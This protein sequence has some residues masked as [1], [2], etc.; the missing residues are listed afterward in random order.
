MSLLV[1]GGGDL[2]QTGGWSLRAPCICS[3]ALYR[4]GCPLPIARIFL[5]ALAVLIGSV[6]RGNDRVG[7]RGRY[8]GGIGAVLQNQQARWSHGTHRFLGRDLVLLWKQRQ[9][10]RR[11]KRGIATSAVSEGAVACDGFDSVAGS[12]GQCKVGGGGAREG[13]S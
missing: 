4:Q 13:C 9:V 3:P 12:L 5:S 8:P 11:K 10:T 2:L 1:R 6:E 7:R